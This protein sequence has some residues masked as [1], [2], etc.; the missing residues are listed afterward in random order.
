MLISL[1]TAELKNSIFIH[2]I[3]TF[4]N[5]FTLDDYIKKNINSNIKKFEF[6]RKFNGALHKNVQK[7][8]SCLI[9]QCIMTF[10]AHSTPQN[11]Q[12]KLFN[13]SLI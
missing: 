1:G 9:Y 7:H 8:C 6:S 12:V 2:Y 5:R 11:Q 3:Q 10:I 13:I 4:A